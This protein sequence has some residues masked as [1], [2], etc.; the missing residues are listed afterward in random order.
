[1]PDNNQNIDQET[2]EILEDV[3]SE[4][5]EIPSSPKTVDYFAKVQRGRQDPSCHQFGAV[6]GRD[7]NKSHPV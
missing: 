5:I 7:N 3:S 4:N 2:G 6:G 1:M